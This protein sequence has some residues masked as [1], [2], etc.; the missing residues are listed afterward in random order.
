MTFQ[1]LHAPIQDIV[2][3]Y[4]PDG[5]PGAGEISLFRKLPMAQIKEQGDFIFYDFTKL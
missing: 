2:Y 3:I 5:F 4:I 1:H